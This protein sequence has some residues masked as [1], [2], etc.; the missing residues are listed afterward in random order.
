MLKFRTLNR[1]LLV[2]SMS[3]RSVCSPALK[4]DVM[5]SIL[6]AVTDAGGGVLPGV[7]VFFG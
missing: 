5:G 3:F 1:T 6:G 2:L 4:A 7:G